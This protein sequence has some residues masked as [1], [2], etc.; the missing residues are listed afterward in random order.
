M[1]AD[2]ANDHRT[3]C[4]EGTGA[5]LHILR[6]DGRG[7][8]HGCTRDPATLELAGDPLASGVVADGNYAREPGV[9]VGKLRQH[10]IRARHPNTG[11]QRTLRQPGIDQRDRLE[12]ASTS[13]G[14]DHDAGVAGRADNR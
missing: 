1:R 14:V 2:V 11:N 12:Q 3:R 5:D 4:D 6:D 9:L 10:V 8:D 7:M 13:H